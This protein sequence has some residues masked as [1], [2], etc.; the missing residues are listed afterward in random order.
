MR[1]LFR[2]KITIDGFLVKTSYERRQR[3]LASSHGR[4]RDGNL[5]IRVGAACSGHDR[6][7]SASRSI[8]RGSVVMPTLFRISRSHT[9]K[10]K[11]AV[12][13]EPVHTTQFDCRR[14]DPAAAFAP[15]E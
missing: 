11:S 13:R 4:E 12:R 10:P 8:C 1:A 15:R 5:L 2:D 7:E 14:A 3:L 9:I 6:Y